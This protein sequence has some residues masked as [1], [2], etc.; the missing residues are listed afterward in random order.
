MEKNEKRK[1]IFL[2]VCLFLVFSLIFVRLFDV[3][4]LKHDDYVAKAASEHIQENKIEASRGEIYM[5]DGNTPAKVVMNETVYTVVF[6]PLIVDEEKAKSVIEKYAKDKMVVEWED[7]FRDK[8]RRYYVVARNVRYETAKKIQEEGLSGV[9]F[10]RKNKRVY[11]EGELASTVLGFV[12]RDGVGQY[13]VEGSFNEKLSGTD[14]SLKAVRDVNGIALSIGDDNVETPAID[15]EDVVLTIDRNIQS[16][17]EQTLANQINNS[18]ATNGSVVVMDPNNGRVLAMANIPN[19][20]PENYGNVKDARAYINNA[21]EEP[22]EAASVCKT[23]TYAAGVD[24][25]LIT[26]DT[27]YYNTNEMEV[28]GLVFHSAYEGL[29]GQTITFQTAFAYSLNVGSATILKM[30][31]G[32]EFN[33]EGRKKLYQYFMNYGLGQYTGIELYEA[34]GFVPT[35]NQY[36]YTMNYT[37]VTMTFGQGMNLTMMQVIAAYSAIIN[38][39]KYYNPT[40]VAGDFDENGEFKKKE[41]NK[42]DRTVISEEASAE[43]RGFL[44]GNR[45]KER[46]WGIDPAG[47]DIGGK[48]GTGQVVIDGRYSEGEE[49]TLATYVGF[50]GSAG[51]KPAYIIMVKMWGEGKY[52]TGNDDTEP[53]FNEISNYLINYLKVEPK[54]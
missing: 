50:G 40:I 7:V 11:P 30:M 54:M 34:P 10:E 18:S 41:I 35:P 23:F 36:D 31:S 6:D 32:G 47:Y 24:M 44:I 52:L 3:Q 20:D 38:G 26:R 14:G 8:T 2:K 4:V 21:L 16:K 1:I 39:G 48:T 5:M 53:V 17:A 49:E 43:M 29:H 51:E 13:G 33:E 9:S 28:D 45:E 27:T 19:Y 46:M 37:Y 15:G 12:N 25:G 22:F 42:S